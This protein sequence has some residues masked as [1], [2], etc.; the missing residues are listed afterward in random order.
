[1][2]RKELNLSVMG[3]LG[4]RPTSGDLSESSDCRG[5][6]DSMDARLIDDASEPVEAKESAWVRGCKARLRGVR[7]REQPPVDNHV[8]LGRRIMPE[9]CHATRESE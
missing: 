2:D 4:P 9:L 6:L 7:R 1:M 8:R 3:V 5:L